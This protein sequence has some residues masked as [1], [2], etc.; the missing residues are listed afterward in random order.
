MV[1]CMEAWFFADKDHLA[2]YFGD[3]FH[4]DA[5]RPR[6]DIEN[7]PRADVLSSLRAATRD[8]PKGEYSKGQH[9]FEILR[10]IDPAKVRASSPHAGQLLNTLDRLC[11]SE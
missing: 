2:E 3:A 6:K 5:L 10:Q 8:C 7:I 9:S 4:P 1:Q 11:G